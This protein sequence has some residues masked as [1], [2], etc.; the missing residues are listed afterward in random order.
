MA[1]TGAGLEGVV[2]TSSKI[3]FIDGNQGVLSY[4]GYNIHTL[5]ENA[6]FE[7]TIY[8]LWNGRLPNPAE[9]EKLKS[10][11]VAE[12]ELPEQVTV[13]LRNVP[14]EALPMDVLRTAVSMLGLYDPLA[15]DN[16][17]EANIQKAIKLMS[18]VSTLG[19]QLRS[20]SKWK[21]SSSRRSI[22]W[23]RCQLPLHP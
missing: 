21:G 23:L 12:R 11:L 4:F 17:P 19:D 5:A 2:A 22:A 6:T 9:L 20:A 3:C 10:S 8:L 18:R 15:R 16:S 13:F 7:E 1:S 14:K